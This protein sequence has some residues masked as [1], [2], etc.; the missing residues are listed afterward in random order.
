MPE[1]TT[2]PPVDEA[3]LMEFLGRIVV[4]AGATLAAALVVIGDKLGLYR[5]LAAA[6][7]LRPHELAERTGTTERY[8]REWLSAQAAGGYITYDSASSASRSRPSRRSPSPTR[9]AQSTSRRCFNW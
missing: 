2:A 1:T 4:D 8:V 6:G 3:K 7:P 5:A 9:T